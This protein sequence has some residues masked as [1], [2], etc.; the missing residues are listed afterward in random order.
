MTKTVSY[1]EVLN[2]AQNVVLEFGADY[3]YPRSDGSARSDEGCVYFEDGEPSCIVGHVL[4]RL[5]VTEDSFQDQTSNEFDVYQ[6]VRTEPNLPIEF[7]PDALRF[8]REAQMMQ[9][10][11]SPWGV[12]VSHAAKSVQW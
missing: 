11:G 12:A 6:M 3:V 4:D 5:G 1:Q 7:S 9:D 2:I 8:L 10:E